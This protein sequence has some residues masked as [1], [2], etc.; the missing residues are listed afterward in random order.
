LRLVV[1]GERGTA[2]SLRNKE[3]TI[4]GKT[5]TA[6]N[7]HGEDH[8]IFVGMAPLEAP[9]IVVCAIVENA[10]HGS[11]VAAPVAAKVIE[12]YMTKSRGG[13]SVAGDA[14]EGQP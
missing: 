2:R 13:R 10:G 11:E 8:S 4:G 1:Q 12:A 7:P 6:Q 9:E 3:Y 5:G 14:P